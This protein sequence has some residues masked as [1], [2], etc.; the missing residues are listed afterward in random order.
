MGQC[1]P[2][3]DIWSL[4]NVNDNSQHVLNANERGEVTELVREIARNGL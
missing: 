2:A 1:L 3:G 4:I